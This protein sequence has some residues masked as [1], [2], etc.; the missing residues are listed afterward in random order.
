MIRV[1]Q[2]PV[3]WI[4]NVEISLMLGCFWISVSEPILVDPSSDDA[5]FVI[6]SAIMFWLL[7][8]SYVK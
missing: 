1:I 6:S 7:S 3:L 8:N 5:T 4:A 2:L